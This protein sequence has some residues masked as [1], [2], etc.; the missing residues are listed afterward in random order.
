MTAAHEQERSAHRLSGWLVL[1]RPRIAVMVVLMA[2]LGAYLAPGDGGWGRFFEASLYVLLVTGAASVF[3]QVLERETDALMPRTQHRPLVTGSIS[4]TAA[5]VYGLVM[6]VLGVAGM[7]LRFNLLAALL[8][9]VTLVLYVAVYTP[10]KR[11]SSLNTIVGA[12]PGAAPPLLG[13]TA[14]AG[15][16]GPWAWSLFALLFVWQFPHFMAIAY[17]Y[18]DDY[19]QAGHR[20]L[21]DERSGPGA[22]GRQALLYAIA[23]LPVSLLPPLGRITY[24]VYGPGALI[25]GLLYLAPAV[26]FALKEN[27]ERARLL[28]FASLLY[29][30]AMFALIV[31]DHWLLLHN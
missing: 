1:L 6:G 16:V 9:V 4:V 15:G 24:V 18:R 20:M 8:L 31:F 21:A 19:A 27:R 23:I 5:M 11:V 10:L 2:V 17:L 25:L 14:L 29:L 13:Y 28:M 30:P 26:L 3:N 22:A 7:A 12:I